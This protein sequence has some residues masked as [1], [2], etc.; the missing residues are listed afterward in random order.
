MTV[1]PG[2]NAMSYQGDAMF[3]MSDAMLLATA[4]AGKSAI[5]RPIGASQ[6]KDFVAMMMIAISMQNATCRKTGVLQG[7][8]TV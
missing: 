1:H 5:L 8:G 6:R 3:L 2:K 4:R 7:R